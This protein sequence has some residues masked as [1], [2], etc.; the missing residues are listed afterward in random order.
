MFS[1]SNKKQAPNNKP[2]PVPAPPSIVSRDLSI[3]GDL[4]SDGEIQIDGKVNGD[5]RTRILIVGE[6]AKVKGEI[7]AETCH[8]LGRVDGQIKAKVVKL[9]DTAHVVGDILHEDLSIET[10]AFLEGHCKRMVIPEDV[11]KSD[12]EAAADAAKQKA[13]A[14][15]KPA[16]ANAK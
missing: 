10:G 13:H 8:V 3:V 16:A 2:T 5:I 6:S 14:P 11:H 9:A 12:K 15:Q 4:L 7:V 1:K